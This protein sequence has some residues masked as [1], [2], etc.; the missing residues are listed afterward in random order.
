MIPIRRPTANDKP[1]IVKDAIQELIELSGICREFRR[2]I[3]DAR[4]QVV[5]MDLEHA[6]V[7]VNQGERTMHLVRR[8]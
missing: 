7:R 3:P 5:A 4:V 1:E 8:A 2:G 6:A